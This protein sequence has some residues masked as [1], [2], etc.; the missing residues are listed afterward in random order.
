[1]LYDFERHLGEVERKVISLEKHGAQARAVIL[2]RAY[3]TSI[4]DLWDAITNKE[5]LPRWFAIVEGELQLGGR[6]QVQGNAGGKIIECNPPHK[7]SLTWEFSGDVSW[8]DVALTAEGP[9]SARLTLTHTSKLSPHWEQYGPGATGV[10]WELGLLGLAIHFADPKADKIDEEA[11]AAS[12]EGKAFGCGSSKQWSEAAIAAGE[13][14]EKARAWDAR[15]AA[16]YTGES[17]AT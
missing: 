9:E 5:R 2:S 3:E 12:A 17:E 10:G 1:M 14:P 6:Y 11:F 4:E 16:F 13:E 8:I 15:I 7:F